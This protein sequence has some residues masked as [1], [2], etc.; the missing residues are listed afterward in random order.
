MKLKPN[1][2]IFYLIFLLSFISIN[3]LPTCELELECVKECSDLKNNNNQITIGNVNNNNDNANNKHYSKSSFNCQPGDEITFTITAVQEDTTYKGGFIAKLIITGTDGASSTFISE[4]SPQIISCTPVCV[5]SPSETLQFHGGTDQ[6][7][8]FE[9]SV[10][11]TVAT[12]KIPYKIK[13]IVNDGQIYSIETTRYQSINF[14]DHVIPEIDGADKSK[15]SIKIKSI[16]NNNYCKLYKGTNPND[17]INIGDEIL[18]TQ[19]ITFAPTGTNFGYFDLKYTVIVMSEELEGEHSIIFNVCYINCATCDSYDSLNPERKKCASCIS[20]SSFFVEGEESDYCFSQDEISNRFQ[21]YYFKFSSTEYKKCHISCKKCS[22]SAS[23]CSICNNLY[24]K[25]QDKPTPICHHIDQINSWGNYYLSDPPGGDTYNLCTNDCKTCKLNS[26]NCFSCDS[27]SNFYFFSDDLYKCKSNTA[28]SNNYYLV[29]GTYLVKET[30]C[31]T[32]DNQR[33]KKRL[34]NKGYIIR[35]LLNDKNNN[36][37]LHPIKIR[38][39]KI[40]K[41]IKFLMIIN[42]F[43]LV[44]PNN[45]I[46]LMKFNLSKISLIIKGTGKKS[47]WFKCSIL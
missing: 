26:Y 25:V 28:I 2:F 37:R 19:G 22:D 24:Y 27:N 15:I 7:K 33:N 31:N 20:E 34:L 8:K 46:F 42:L 36:F 12:I 38:I 13:N 9:F 29:D 40:V 6:Y 3:T 44:L 10:A 45:I 30:I 14:Q 16:Q 18:L 4:E 32:I 43:T 11:S 47:V 17:L 35:I 1:M 5:L 41:V 23:S 39:F 21:D